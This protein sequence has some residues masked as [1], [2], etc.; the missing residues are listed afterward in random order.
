MTISLEA[1]RQALGF[2]TATPKTG[3][4]KPRRSR[5]DFGD[6]DSHW[7]KVR[8]IGRNY[9]FGN[10]VRDGDFGI[11]LGLH[12]EGYLVADKLMRTSMPGI[13]AAGEI[14]DHRFKQAAT[15]AGQGVAAAMEVEKYLADLEDRTY[16]GRAETYEVEMAA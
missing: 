12:D 9:P 11:Y 1:A 7:L 13:F 5:T 8:R 16:P 10:D 3:R 14:Q 2:A 4:L 6:A 15:S